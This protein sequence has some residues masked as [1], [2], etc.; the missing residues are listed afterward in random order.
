MSILLVYSWVQISN[1]L[2]REEKRENETGEKEE[3]EKKERRESE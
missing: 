1:V 2:V 3:E